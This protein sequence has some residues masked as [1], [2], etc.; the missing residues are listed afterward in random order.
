MR[1]NEFSLPLDEATTSTS[2]K[3]AYLTCCVRFIDNDDNIVEDLLFCKPILTNCKAHEL[4]AILNNLFLENNF[5]WKYCVGLC[6]DGARAMSG[7]FGELQTLVQGVAVNAKWTHCLIHR[8]ALAS[9]QLSDHLSGVLE[10]VVKTVNFIKARPLK[11]RLFQR[12]CDKSRAD[13][14]SL[15]QC[16]VAFQRQSSLTCVRIEKRNLHIFKRRKPCTCYYL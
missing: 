1:G 7:R 3:D 2:D 5:Q 6:T 14:N 16:K 9:Q 15:L 4:F 13:H 11:A 12:L 10:V 8:E